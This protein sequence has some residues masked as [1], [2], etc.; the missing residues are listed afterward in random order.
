M[1]NSTMRPMMVG[2]GFGAVR[3]AVVVLF[4]V[5]SV[6]GHQEPQLYA[7]LPLVK[8]AQVTVT[9]SQSPGGT[10]SYVYTVANP[11][12][13]TGPISTITVAVSRPPGGALLTD[14]ALVNTT[15]FDQ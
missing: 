9:V 13:N 8:A 10:F 15:P 3:G 14:N 6:M 5:G 7:A 12:S 2:P 4:V 1:R 11:N